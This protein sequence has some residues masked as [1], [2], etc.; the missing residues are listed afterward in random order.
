MSKLFKLKEWLT[1]EEAAKHLSTVLGE[2]VAIADIYRLTLD[3]HLVLSMNFPNGTYGNLGEAVSLENTKRFTPPADLME[4]MRKINPE[5]GSEEIIVSDYIG[6]GQFINWEEKVV[7]IDGVWDLAMLASERI[8]V[9][10]VY[11]Q[12]IGGPKIDLVGLDGAFV[13]QGNVFCRLVESFDDNEYQKGSL[14]VKKQLEN[15]VENNE[16][17]EQKIKSMW[18]T[19]DA[20]R[21]EYL[22]ERDSRPRHKDYFPAGG[23][24]KDGVYTVK[25]AAIVGFLNR[26]NE[27]PLNERPLS[28]K[29]RNSMLILI[30][31][32]CKEANFDLQQRGI[33]GALAASTETLGKPLT[34]DTIRGILKQ[35]KDLLQ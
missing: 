35:V 25:T 12:L 2:E 28:T 32:L 15:C 5:R 22:K 29:E 24:P 18:D 21:K 26:I 7:A 4:A 30:A 9:E 20:D 1:V 3:K 8:D 19:F 17:P 11:H 6:D 27:N 16:I 34:D 23:L 33:A 13:K 10:Y 14:A 31:A